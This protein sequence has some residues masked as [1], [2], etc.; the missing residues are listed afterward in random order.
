MADLCG[1]LNPPKMAG[2]WWG[3]VSS[4]W[5]PGCWWRPSWR[6]V[7]RQRSSPTWPWRNWS[8]SPTR[9]KN[10]PRIWPRVPCLLS[11]T[12]VYRTGFWSVFQKHTNASRLLNID[13]YWDIASC[14]Q[15]AESGPLR[16]LGIYLQKHPQN[17]LN[18]L[19]P[20]KILQH[21]LNGGAFIGVSHAIIAA[22][23]SLNDV[24]FDSP[25]PADHRMDHPARHRSNWR[26]MSFHGLPRNKYLQKNIVRFAAEPPSHRH[27]EHEVLTSAI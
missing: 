3:S 24:T 20:S 16:Q 21:V 10:W 7:T 6:W 4:W 5:D 14:V 9:W 12:W 19:S 23:E 17:I 13:A 25:E 1:C 27:P 8:P 26:K 2:G 18:D 22:I 11:A 15:E